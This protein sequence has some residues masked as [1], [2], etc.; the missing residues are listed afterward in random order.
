M[1]T[2]FSKKPS[3]FFRNGS[4]GSG[5]ASEVSIALLGE[6]GS[7]KSGIYI[8]QYRYY[9]SVYVNSYKILIQDHSGDETNALYTYVY[10]NIYIY[11][12]T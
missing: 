1:M 3:S 2:A 11:I 10:N 12:Y 8:L 7:G 6:Q 5:N 9:L 4:N